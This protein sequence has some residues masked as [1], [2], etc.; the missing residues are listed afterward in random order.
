MAKSEASA[1]KGYSFG[2]F[3]GVFTPSILTILGVVMYLRMGW[4]VGMAG[5]GGAILIILLATSVTLIT[6]LSLSALATNMKVGG[7]GAYFIISR[8]LGVETG[9]AIGIPLFLAQAVGVSFYVAGFTEAFVGVVPGIDPIVVGLGTLIGLT[10]LTLISADLALKSQFVVMGA[11]VLSLVSFFAGSAPAGLV[12]ATSSADTAAKALDS[13]QSSVQFLGFWAVFAVFFPAV[14]GIEAGISMSGDLKDPA[15]SLPLGTLAAIGCGLLIYLAIPIFLYSKVSDRELLIQDPLLIQK[16]AKWQSLVIA[17]V[18]AASLSSAMGAIL[19]A[20]RTLQALARDSAAPRFLGKGVGPKGNPVLAT[21]LTFAI[22]CLGI[23]LGDL[24]KIAPVLSMFFLTSYGILNLASALED[25]MQHPSWRPSFKTPAWL[26]FFGFLI[27]LGIMLMID[28]TSALVAM[29]VSFSIY[30][31]MKRRSLQARWG[32]MRLGLWMF[33]V[34]EI[35]YRIAGQYQ[36]EKTWKPNIL[37]LSGA[38]NSRWQLIQLAHEI[39][40]EKSFLTVA[41]I[42]P[43]ENW[44]PERVRSA[45]ETIRDFLKKRQIQA[46]VRTVPATTVIDGAQALIRAYGFGP[47]VPNTLLLGDTEKKSNVRGFAELIQLAHRSG[48]NLAMIRE[49]PSEKDDA[50]DVATTLSEQVAVQGPI[51]IWW[52]GR[53]QNI[54]FM[55]ALASLIQRSERWR[56][57]EL[58]IKT[59]VDSE[60]K[61]GGMETRLNEFIQSSRLDA[62][63]EV[64]LTD[65]AKSPFETIR[66][67]SQ[68]SGLVFLGIRPPEDDEPMDEYVRY[69]ESLIGQLDGLP[70]T[71]LT[72]ASEKVDFLKIFD[73]M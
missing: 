65:S 14:T 68:N 55:M 39:T 49:V 52:S 24:N 27:C 57:G 61:R 11:I 43:V 71:F 32:D 48:K 72:L 53:R 69:Y 10:T 35:L 59:I 60:E 21:L 13:V 56:A 15:K 4:T 38:P 34:R 46:F 42:C 20:P 41:T 23:V 7:G 18:W 9:A 37:A 19:G 63:A 5:L 58:A 50:P 66:E 54:G 16:V 8:S 25:W 70:L 28:A 67:S 17:G 36:D 2:T 3:Q 33:I 26:S 6:G 64:I 30:L 51:D 47:L 73:E 44:T 62:R 22:A 40:E 45:S 31:V 29:G 12:E 1:V